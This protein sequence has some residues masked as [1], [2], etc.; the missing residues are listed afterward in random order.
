MLLTIY[1][2]LL[3]IVNFSLDYVALYITGRLTSSP[4]ST[5]RMCVSA[6][7]GAAFAV[8][9]LVFDMKGFL[10]V[11]ASAA[12]CLLMCR[13]AYKKTD[14]I[15]CIGTALLLFSVG[16][17]LG[18]AMTALSSLTAGYRDS[19]DGKSDGDVAL[20]AVAATAAA[21]TAAAARYARRRCFRGTRWVTVE[22]GGAAKTLTAL[23]DSGCF[24][25]EPLSGRSAL[26]VRADA[27]IGILPQEVTDAASADDVS[28]A[29]A[30]LPPGMLGRIRLIPVTGVL[31]SGLLLGYV[32]DGI[33]VERGKRQRRVDAV[34]AL[35][36][37][38]DG[39]A[40]CDAII[41]GD[42]I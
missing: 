18:G 31:G 35:S 37:D 41:P 10:Y 1:A 17:A 30:L 16:A 27:L 40:G 2:D 6:A 15:G 23:P 32:P 19:V 25:R 29:A 28:A 26:I 42:L 36:S 11:L 4:S 33:E 8:C 34:L 24:L 3:F 9:A 20:F 39:F 21:L 7:L 12:V 38:K 5:L 14:L 13:C 22:D